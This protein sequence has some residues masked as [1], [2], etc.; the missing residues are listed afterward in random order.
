MQEIISEADKT[1][2]DPVHLK[3]KKMLAG[4]LG[5]YQAWP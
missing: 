1:Q 2:P 3:M 4:M 5:D